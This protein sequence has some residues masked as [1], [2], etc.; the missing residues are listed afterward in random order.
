MDSLAP[1]TNGRLNRELVPG[2]NAAAAAVFPILLNFKSIGT[3]Q[4]HKSNYIIFL[5][6]LSPSHALNVRYHGVGTPERILDGG[7]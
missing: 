2:I 1:R 5:D 6:Q 7:P 4:K 3:A